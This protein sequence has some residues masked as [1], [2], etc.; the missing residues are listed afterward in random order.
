MASSRTRLRRLA[1]DRFG[2]SELAEEQ[3]EPMRAL[4]AGRDVLAVLPTGAGKSAI[5]QLPAL[6]MDRP[7]LV[8]SPLLALQRDQIDALARSGAARAEALNGDTGE[9]RRREILS[10]AATGEVPLLYLTPE[11]LADPDRLADL[12]ELRP[13]LVAVDEA[14]CVSAWGYDFRPDYLRLGRAIRRLGRPPVAA[15]TATASPPVRDD[16][17][18]WLGLTDPLVVVG[19]LERPN[20]YLA[21][22]HCPDEPTRRARL[23][24]AVD[25]LT[26]PG[27]VYVPT[28]R[29][30]EEV[31]GQ[32][33][34]AG[35]DARPYH[36]GLSRA[37]RDATHRGFIEGRLPTVAATTAFGMGIDKPDIRWVCH[38]ALPD[39]PDAY[40]QEVGRAGRDG[41]PAT[42]LLLF[43]ETDTGLRRYF[44]S[45]T[46]RPEE[47][48]AVIRELRAGPV[49]S[50]RALAE[51]AGVGTRRLTQI[52]A[53]LAQVGA[54]S[55]GGRQPRWA[56][57]GPDPEDAAGLVL[58]QVRRQREIRRSRVEMIRGYAETEACRTGYL[59]GY[60]GQRMARPCGHCD[61]CATGTAAA[62]AGDGP[63]RTGSA[64]RHAEWGRGV[65]VGA[66]PDRVTV[67][68]DEVGYRTLA[69]PDVLD[70]ELLRRA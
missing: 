65:V 22:A 18:G 19:G 43:R 30:A 7:T 8:V 33:R 32:L 70:R 63:Y 15:L 9:T 27:I 46:P 12:A 21:A 36:A 58:R 5:Y 13:A 50:R 31:A 59:L 6:L 52:L 57:G 61:T 64:V 34:A 40:L 3:E 62:R 24:G 51:R 42:A 16:I 28:R 38:A 29:A 37:V 17:A 20:L 35:R 25:E 11:Q 2:W 10:A 48:G 69:L 26:G 4:L 66:E 1:A 44:A 39:S 60:F 49:P 56:P 45:G 55:V 54:V 14:H 41:A 53:L 23:L 67:L 47:V 68:F